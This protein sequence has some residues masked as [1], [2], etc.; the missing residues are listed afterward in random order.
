M[1]LERNKKKYNQPGADTQ[2]R[3]L[4]SEQ[5][6]F[7]RIIGKWKQ[8]CSSVPDNLYNSLC[9]SSTCNKT[10]Q[11]SRKHRQRE[12][13]CLPCIFLSSEQKPVSPRTDLPS[14]LLEHIQSTSLPWDIFSITHKMLFSM[15]TVSR[16]SC[17]GAFCLQ[18]ELSRERGL[19]RAHLDQVQ[20]RAT[21]HTHGSGSTPSTALLLQ[22]PCSQGSCSCPQQPPPPAPYCTPQGQAVT[23]E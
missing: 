8:S 2:S 18:K 3:K 11:T 19:E 23:T 9:I 5:L 6:K 21:Q 4:Q 1:K 10:H 12:A 14:A 13:K 15:E 16:S 17:Q 20:G 22:Q 7:G